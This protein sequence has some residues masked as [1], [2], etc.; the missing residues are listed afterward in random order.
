MQK[1]SIKNTCCF[2]GHRK[3]VH[4]QELL[5]RLSTVITEL[6]ES[7]ISIFLFGSRSKFNDLC[8]D[9]VS[10]LREKYPYIRR[11]YVRAEYPIISKD[12]EMYLLESYE[13]TFFPTE[14]SRA[15][16]SVYVERNMYMIDNSTVCVMYYREDISYSKDCLMKKSGTKLALDYATQKKKNILRV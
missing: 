15:G 4:S 13:E 5:E 6:V 3:I 1:N 12:Y 11:I 8:H 7:G 9:I 16:K 2:I 10:R 14:L